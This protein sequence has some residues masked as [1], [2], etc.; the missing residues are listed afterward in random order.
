M[1]TLAMPT[2]PRILELLRF[3]DAHRRHTEALTRAT[4]EQ[5]NIFK[6][7]GIGHYEV[8][9]HSPM[10]G[11]LLNPKGSHGQGDVFLRLFLNLMG[12]ANF[13]MDSA[14]LELEY[15]IGTVTDKS[16]GRIDIVI[17]DGSGNAIFIE[18]K[19]YAGD[20]E[21][22]LRRYRQR[23]QRA[24]LFYLTLHC[25]LPSGFTEET[26]RE[27]NVTCISYATHIRD[28][29]AA[30]QKEAASLPHVRESI[31]QYLHLIMELTGQSTTQT[32]NQELIGKITADDDSLAAY[33]A[34][35][36]ELENVKVALV[37]KLDAQLDEAAKAANLHRDGRIEKLHEKYA[38]I[39][40]TTDSLAKHNLRIGFTFDRG[41][42]QDLDFGFQ[43]IDK[44]KPCDIGEKLLTIFREQFHAFSPTTPTEWWPAWADFEPPYG[45]WG[46][47]AFQAIA[48]GELAANMK[49]KLTIMSNIA[50]QVC[51]D[52]VPTSN[53][54]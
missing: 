23:D 25:T 38:G 11:N 2:S 34:L 42:F 4:G 20:Q 16:G 41:G 21:N 27:I 10:L 46:N 44:D 36:S 37:T 31:S 53:N 6:I 47:E 3:A 13:D 43:K 29:L 30:C 17:L 12:I 19:I 14:R 5:F 49:N 8:G 48:S 39:Y 22:Q 7:L 28:W 32:M 45:Y 26:L 24:H 50:K 15:H 52:E 40:F 33:F 1:Q 51:P 18:N 9:T 54:S 35:T